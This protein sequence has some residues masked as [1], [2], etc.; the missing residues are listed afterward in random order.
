MARFNP[1]GSSQ[2]ISD[3]INNIAKA[4]LGS[5]DTDAALARARASDAS[6]KSSLA[7]AR[8]RN[9]NAG[10]L[11]SL[12]KAGEGLSND[13]AFQGVAASLLGIPTFPAEQFGPPA[14]GEVVLGSPRMSNLARTILGEYGT[15][16]QM[17]EAFSNIGLGNQNML[18]GNMILGGSPEQAARGALRLAPQGGKYQNPSFAAT[19]LADTLLNNL[20]E[21]KLIEKGDLA[22][23]GLINEG[24]VEVQNLIEAGKLKT[25]ELET[26][27][28]ENIA[29]ADREAE[30][31]WR[32]EIEETKIEIANIEDERERETELAK[33]EQSQSEQIDKQYIVADGVITMSPALAKR[34]GVETT[35]ETNNGKKVFAIDVRQGAGKIPVLLGTGEGATTIYVSDANLDKLNVQQ[36]EG[37]L[38]IPEGALANPAKKSGSEKDPAYKNLTSEE[39]KTV[40]NEANDRIAAVF[41]EDL[42]TQVQL[43]L[44]DYVVNEVNDAAAQK[45]YGQATTDILGPLTSKGSM[46]LGGYNGT[47]I[48][49]HFHE[50]WMSFKP[51]MKLD[52]FKK[53]VTK[54]ASEVG[55]TAPEIAHIFQDSRYN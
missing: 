17:S 47:N 20:E 12:A 8:E 42:P 44:I 29:T 26:T 2:Q 13:P 23:R 10:I 11:E 37:K 15:A 9:A 43:G 52:K 48:P 6:A 31:G 18:A 54:M 14:Q 40:K 38:V 7:Q 41:G 36:I 24:A 16:N 22:E 49:V 5:P 32:A 35:T 3:S 28:K 33:L 39:A 25:T 53:A 30:N 55:Y 1:Y 19:E 45:E 21:R 46:K 50:L 34:M 51:Q 4:L 27:S